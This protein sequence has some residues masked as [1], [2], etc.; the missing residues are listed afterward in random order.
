MSRNTIANWRQQESQLSTGTFSACTDVRNARLFLPRKSHSLN[1]TGVAYNATYEAGGD[2]AF[3]RPPTAAERSAPCEEHVQ[4]PALV[5]NTW[6]SD[7]NYA[8]FL[9]DHLPMIYWMREKAPP[10]T[11]VIIGECSWCANSLRN[12]SRW[13][14]SWLDAPLAERVEWLPMERMTCVSGSLFVAE[15]R[16]SARR[17]ADPSY[18]TRYP[19]AP[20]TLQL[21]RLIARVSH[22]AMRLHLQSTKD[23]DN[24]PSIIYYSRRPSEWLNGRVFS[25]KQDEQIG[26]MVHSEMKQFRRGERFIT[27]NGM[28]PAGYPRPGYPMTVAQQLT[29]F[30]SAR[31]FI[32]PHG[33]AFANV[34][35]MRPAGG[36]ENSC[37][38]GARN[39]VEFV[40]GKES[41]AVQADCPYVRSFYYMLGSASWVRW[42]TILYSAKATSDLKVD[43]SE[44][45]TVVDSIF[46]HAAKDSEDLAPHWSNIE[47]VTGPAIEDDQE[48]EDVSDESVVNRALGMYWSPMYVNQAREG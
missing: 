34:L 38:S 44:V 15:P 17:F 27:Y 30:R 10:E 1:W 14:L 3:W 33:G 2:G 36:A 46:K 45:R 32:G 23:D 48:G 37:S 5:W 31:L 22:T 21:P 39:V 47:G 9:H 24:W 20:N 13:L 25:P 42:H 16:F 8:H 18:Q 19:G 11:R 12:R 4:G 26:R 35:W 7:F 40:C 43:L 41:T 28:Q 6:Y 29:L